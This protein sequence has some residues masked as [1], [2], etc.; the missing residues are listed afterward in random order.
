MNKF[1]ILEQSLKE[2]NLVCRWKDDQELQNMHTQGLASVH[3]S[4]Q[5]PEKIVAFLGLWPTPNPACVEFGTFWVDPEFQGKGLA[6]QIF[7]ECCQIVTAKNLGAFLIS[8]N[9]TVIYLAKHYGWLEETDKALVNQIRF[10]EQA[11]RRLFYFD[12]RS[13]KLVQTIY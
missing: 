9:P 1:K 13:K 2:G 11:T 3:Y 6:R 4:E 12:Q 10:S 5:D 8:A 7:V